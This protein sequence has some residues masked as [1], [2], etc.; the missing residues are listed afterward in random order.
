M[1]SARR[2][3]SRI[4]TTSSITSGSAADQ[5]PPVAADARAARRPR[6]RCVS[7]GVRSAN[8]W[9]I[10]NVRTMP[11]RTRSCGSSA[12]M[13]LAVE[14]DAARGRPQHAGEQ[15]D[16][17]G[18]A[19]AVRADQRVARAL[20][21]PAATRCWSRRGRRSASPGRPSRARPSWSAALRAARHRSAGSAR[22][23]RDA[24]RSERNGSGPR[25]RCAR[26]RPAR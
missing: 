13:S 15:I 7:S 23:S 3:R 25:A 16:Q 21:D 14:Q 18:L 11:S 4:S 12:V 20:L 1:T 26:G 2:K 9:L 6:A 17:R 5:A 22:A 19:G 8:S 10:W 24:R